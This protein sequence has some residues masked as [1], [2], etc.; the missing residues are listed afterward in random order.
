VKDLQFH[1]AADIFPLMDDEPFDE[2][3]EDIRKHGLQVKIELY[4][5]KVLD[6]RNRYKACLLAQK[7]ILTTDVDDFV[8]DPLAHVVSLNRHRRHLNPSQ[9]AIAAGK[10]TEMYEAEAK[11]AKERQGKRPPEGDIK[12]LV[13][14]PP[15]SGQTRDKIGKQFGIS[16]PMVDR[17]KRVVEKGPLTLVKAVEEGRMSVS[18]ADKLVKA[19]DAKEMTVAEVEQEAKAAIATGGRFRNKPKPRGT[20]GR[21]LVRNPVTEAMQL[22]AMAT[23]DLNRIRDNDPQREEAFDSVIRWIKTK[24]SAKP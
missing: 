2:L 5:G 20:D 13:S 18:Q 22:A 21:P 11:R 8:T 1:S 24:R 23:M 16:G 14:G 4:D 3:V 12:E 10:A 19:V 6:G 9:L 15:D 7:P 17:G